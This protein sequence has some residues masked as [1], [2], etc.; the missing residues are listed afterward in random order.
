[1]C[2]DR[3]NAETVHFYAKNPEKCVFKILMHP[4]TQ[5]ATWKTYRI[6]LDRSVRFCCLRNKETLRTNRKGQK[7][8]VAIL[9][10][11][12]LETGNNY[13]SGTLA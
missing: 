4:R 11:A 9:D 1:V 3:V 12:E 10:L 6:S 13:T 7:I 2:R 8:V 5:Q